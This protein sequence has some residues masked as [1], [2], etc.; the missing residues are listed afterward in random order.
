MTAFRHHAPRRLPPRMSAPCTAQ[1]PAAL[2][3]LE[4]A[5]DL[6]ARTVWPTHRI[7]SFLSTQAAPAHCKPR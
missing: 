3:A 1:P 5:L 7:R 2:P 4:Q 6:D